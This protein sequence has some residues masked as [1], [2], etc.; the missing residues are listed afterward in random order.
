[1]AQIGTLNTTDYIGLRL[2]PLKYG[3]RLLVCRPSKLSNLLRAHNF[4]W[5]INPPCAIFR[6]FW[7]V[8]VHH[9]LPKTCLSPKNSHTKNAC[10]I[11]K[12][13]NIQVAHSI[14]SPRQLYK[15]NVS[16]ET[17]K[18]GCIMFTILCWRVDFNDEG[19]F[20]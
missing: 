11:Y 18:A 20:C 15:P 9:M 14:L 3:L 7:Y 6:T 12:V 10:T 17:P 4:C 2:G 13:D 16:F 5:E 19:A 1:V 8:T